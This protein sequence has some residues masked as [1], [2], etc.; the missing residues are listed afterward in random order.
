MNGELREVVCGRGDSQPARVLL[1]D[2]PACFNVVH[3]HYDP[4]GKWDDAV[5][6]PAREQMAHAAD[7][8]VRGRDALQLLNL[9]RS[10]VGGAQ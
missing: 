10:F 1:L 8:D 7:F 6:C 5:A 3:A 4:L 2:P 9:V